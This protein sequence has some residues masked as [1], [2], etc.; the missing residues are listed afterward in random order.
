MKQVCQKKLSLKV[1]LYCLSNGKK[2]LKVFLQGPGAR[3]IFR[4]SSRTHR[5]F[6]IYYDQIGSVYLNL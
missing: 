4:L 2:V 5:T 6:T 3:K 1:D